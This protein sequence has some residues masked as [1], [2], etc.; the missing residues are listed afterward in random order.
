MGRGGGETFWGG[1][2]CLGGLGLWEIRGEAKI[3]RFVSWFLLGNGDV[4]DVWGLVE[5]AVGGVGLWVKSP[6]RPAFFGVPSCTQIACGRMTVYEAPKHTRNKEYPSEESS[7]P[8]SSNSLE[9]KTG[10]LDFFPW[11]P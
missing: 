11:G 5:L 4:R 3:R 9:L 6:H 7:P 8:S 1:T 2:D 10:R